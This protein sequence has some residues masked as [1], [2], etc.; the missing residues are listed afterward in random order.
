MLKMTGGVDFETDE[1]FRVR[2]KNGIFRNMAGTFDQ[3]MALALSGENTTK[4]SV[5]G[6]LSRYQ[7]YMVVPSSDD[8]Q[9][10]TSGDPNGNYDAGGS[11]WPHK[12]TT[13]ASDIPYSKS[14][15]PSRTT[16]QTAP[17]VVWCSSRTWTTSSTASRSTQPRTRGRHGPGRRLPRPSAQT[18]PPS[19][20]KVTD[21]DT[22]E[23][24]VH[25]QA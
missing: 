4:A 19:G 13:A 7:E 14:R 12:R 18:M 17:W 20:S 2:F 3:F 15:M 8:T 21:R 9:A 10:A 25:V 16:S 11:A 5:I 1:Q 6:P 23:E 24:V 22:V